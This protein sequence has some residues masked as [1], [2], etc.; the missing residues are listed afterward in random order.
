MKYFYLREDYVV[1]VTSD[2]SEDYAP[3]GETE[4]EGRLRE[5][6]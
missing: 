6:C 3:D 2:D 1:I 5:E 4:L